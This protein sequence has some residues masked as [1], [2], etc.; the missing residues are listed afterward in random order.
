M[1]FYEFDERRYNKRNNVWRYIAIAII[2]TL[3]GAMVTYYALMLD[4]IPE[5]DN[6]RDEQKAPEI[7]KI[8]KQ[9]PTP[10]KEV[11]EP[12]TTQVTPNL[13]SKGD[14]YIRSNNPV[15]EIARK[16]GPA[17][18]GITN[19]SVV[20]VQDFFFGEQEREQE[21]YG[22]GIIV[23]EEGYIVTNYH[24]IAG[25]NELFVILPEGDTVKAELIGGDKQSDVAVLKIDVQNLPVATIGDSDAVRQGEL[26]VAIGNPLGHKLSGTVT[27][28]VISAIN[29]SLEIDGRTMNFIQT[30]AAIS[31]GNSGGALINS[32]GEVIGMNTVKASI[33]STGAEGL[34][35]AIPSNEFI[36]IARELID[37]GI[38]ERPGI[39]IA[40]RALTAEYAK[41]I[42]YPQGIGVQQVVRGGPAHKAGILPG[43]V[44]IKADEKRIKTFEDISDVIREHKVG[45]V[46][47]VTVWRGGDEFTLPVKLEQMQD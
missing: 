14:L 44:I 12:P 15:E 13:G 40:G 43:D 24:V 22:S 16:V 20:R 36:A 1:D 23:S 28:G 30:D 37:H 9:D 34:G 17:I 42:G 33:P 47:N 7:G 38:V 18:V 31:P 27:A 25:A 2:F 8:E 21:G 10:D 6:A 39:G 46:I 11:K 32:K 41:E 45:D 19:K 35:F 26:A 5:K 3:V 29:R 4:D